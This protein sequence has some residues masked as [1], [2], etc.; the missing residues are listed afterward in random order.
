MPK[1][2]WLADANRKKG[3]ELR[4]AQLKSYTIDPTS[5]CWLWSGCVGKDGYGKVKRQGK[6]VR[7]HRLFYEHYVTTIPQG[8]VV[9]HRCDNP[10]CVNPEHLFVGTPLDNERDKDR[11]ARRSPSPSVSHKHRLP[12]GDNHHKA[13]LTEEIVRAIRESNESSYSLAIAYG[14]NASTIQ[15]I[16]RRIIWAHI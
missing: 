4:A 16:K 3:E 8:L 6:T 14:V 10:L 2:Q 5:G 13:V 12:R 15:R 1:G 7:S 11:K 9:C